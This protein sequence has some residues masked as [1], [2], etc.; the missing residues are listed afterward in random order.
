MSVVAIQLGQC[1]NQ[2]GTD[3][4]DTLMNDAVTPPPYS[5]SHS[6]LNDGYKEDVLERFF[7]ESSSSR[8][9]RTTA[10]AVMIDTEPKVIQRCSL[11]AATS[12]M[13]SI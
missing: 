10:R 2:I 9:F 4:F 11:K 3:F 5:S 6:S 12:G 1:G 13:I 8:S 7:C